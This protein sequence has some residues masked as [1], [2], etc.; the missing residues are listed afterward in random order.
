MI[1]VMRV[2]LGWERVARYEERVGSSSSIPS[3]RNRFNIPRL[4]VVRGK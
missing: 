4:P 2:V 1:I 3:D